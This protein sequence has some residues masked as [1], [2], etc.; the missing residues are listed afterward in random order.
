MNFLTRFKLFF[1]VSLFLP[2]IPVFSK[3]PKK[4]VAAQYFT[5]LQ[6]LGIGFG[7]GTSACILVAYPETRTWIWNN[8]RYCGQIIGASGFL[9]GLKWVHEK[10]NCAEKKKKKAK[11][12]DYA[13]DSD[14]SRYTGMV[15]T[16]KKINNR[17]CDPVEN[18]NT[19]LQSNSQWS[20]SSYAA[21][22]I[23]LGLCGAFCHTICKNTIVEDVV[24][25]NQ[26]IIEKVVGY[27]AGL[28]ACTYGMYKLWQNRA[29]GEPEHFDKQTPTEDFI[30]RYQ[31]VVVKTVGTSLGLAA[32]AYGVHK[33]WQNRT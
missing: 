17:A 27:S 8:P 32:C 13:T 10:L 30:R 21:V 19:G 4:E 5:T 3:P 11:K 29:Q 7:I 14:D 18:I 33:A 24:R 6:A 22:A 15:S 31:P 9:Y 16:K 12:S 26:P 1:M 25:Q 28:A 23:E 2:I 20:A